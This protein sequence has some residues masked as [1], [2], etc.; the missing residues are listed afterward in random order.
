MLSP[1]TPKKKIEKKKCLI[2]QNILIGLCYIYTLFHKSNII[3]SLLAQ[4]FHTS[5]INCHLDELLN[6]VGINE[7]S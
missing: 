4:I 2:N 5:F 7:C 3:G 1:L 6:Y